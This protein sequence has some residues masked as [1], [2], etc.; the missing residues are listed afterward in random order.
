M[1]LINDALKR[2]S[3]SHKNQPAPG[4]P[5]RPMQPAASA[6]KSGASSGALVVLVIVLLL[7]GWF[8]WKWWAGSHPTVAAKP[9]A[10]PVAKV[11]A[12]PAPAPKPA[13]APVPVVK[14]APP[15]PAPPVVALAQKPVERVAAPPVVEA[16]WPM[17]LTLKGIFYSKSHPLALINGKTVGPGETVG[18]AVVSK[19]EP[20]RVI[21]EW[22]G[23]TKDLLPE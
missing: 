3:E 8:F 14:P 17:T 10:A 1:S 12:A 9:A 21:V 19:I 16:A 4:E 15:P 6:R 20:N 7:W 5:A 2:A 23:H 18:G 13:P 22:K 11:A